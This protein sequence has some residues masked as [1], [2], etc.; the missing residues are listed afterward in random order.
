MK[1]FIEITQ[2]FQDFTSLSGLAMFS[3]DGRFIETSLPISDELSEKVGKYFCQLAES[4]RS[5]GC[6]S[7]RFVLD[8]D[9]SKLLFAEHSKGAFL[10]MVRDNHEI[11]AIFGA[12]NHMYPAATHESTTATPPLPES[13]VEQQAEIK[14]EPVSEV[15]EFKPIESRSF[16]PSARKKSPA[17]W[18]ISS[19]A[20]GVALAI[21]FTATG[22]LA[23]A[24]EHQHPVIENTYEDQAKADS[25]AKMALEK[26]LAEEAAA[27]AAL[28]KAELMAAEEAKAALEAKLAAPNLLQKQRPPLKPKPK[29]K[30]KRKQETLQ[31]SLRPRLKRK[32]KL[33]PKLSGSPKRKLQHSPL[34]KQRRKKK[35]LGRLLRKEP[36]LRRLA[37]R[38]RNTL[39]RSA[40]TPALGPRRSPKKH[41]SQKSSR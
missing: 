11:D 36:Q 12:F 13:V 25:L 28:K 20:A 9:D 15:S 31:L 37:P 6:H 4:Y 16:S 40:K 32:Q 30:R 27:A 17:I 8:L 22:S 19:A 39:K 34:K 35:P 2:K 41:L 26:K 5:Q 18:A 29:L 33:L 24:D 23:A 3:R 1:S 38:K 14:P 21:G 10:F 7:N